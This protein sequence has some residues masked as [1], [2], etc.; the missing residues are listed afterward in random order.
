[1][2]GPVKCTPKTC[3]FDFAKNLFPAWFRPEE[4]TRQAAV[5]SYM[6]AHQLTLKNVY[7]RAGCARHFCTYRF[8]IYD[9]PDAIPGPVSS[10]RW[11]APSATD[12]GCRLPQGFVF[13]PGRA[14]PIIQAAF[15]RTPD[16]ATPIGRDPVPAPRF[17]GGCG[18]AEDPYRIS[19]AKELLLLS[20]LSN[21]RTCAGV[22]PSLVEEI[23]G[24]FPAWSRNKHFR[25]TRDIVW[26]DPDGDPADRVSFPII[27]NRNGGWGRSAHFAGT[28][29]GAG[30]FISGLFVSEE[31]EKKRYPDVEYAYNNGVSLFGSLQGTVKNLAIT[32]SVFIGSARVAAF[33]GVMCFGGAIENCLADNRILLFGTSGDRNAGGLVGFSVN[34]TISRSVVGGEILGSVYSNV[35]F[36]GGIF[37]AV[38]T[39][40]TMATSVSDCFVFAS[41]REQ[42]DPNVRRDYPAFLAL[43]GEKQVEI[44]RIREGV[45]NLRI[46]KGR[47]VG[48][49]GSVYVVN[50]YDFFQTFVSPSDAERTAVDFVSFVLPQFSDPA[51]ASPLYP[52]FS[53][54]PGRPYFVNEIKPD[55]P[56]M[57]GIA[58]ALDYLF[59]SVSGDVP[60][61]PSAVPP[62][63]AEELH[64]RAGLLRFVSEAADH[65]LMSLS[66]ERKERKSA[67]FRAEL[68]DWIE[69]NYRN[70]LTTEEAARRFF[71]SK[72]Y[73]CRQFRQ[74][75]GLPFAIYLQNFRIRKSKQLDPAKFP[76]LAS[77]AASV[78]FPS[79]YHFERVF[80]QW[81]GTT[82]RAYFDAV[83]RS[84]A[85]PFADEDDLI[86]K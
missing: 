14:I 55:H 63:T 15:D 65:G 49:P 37:G 36:L 9:D 6:H 79:Y 84:A 18:T 12:P 83:R 23:A 8:T 13:R 11:I 51:E 58:A 57:P 19:S 2:N 21:H 30:H 25:L 86:Q 56:G 77:L 81:M 45:L 71:L 80:R 43:H 39:G 33:A 31:E 69:K 10:C 53:G 24:D 61:H 85:T 73:F 17:A 66:V 35:S 78:G 22:D 26:N 40:A 27:A 29:D 60:R 72:S 32:R 47:Y 44:F 34:G 67:K 3:V 4:S 62:E 82:P 68:I 46:G 74:E 41:I 70:K 20:S 54:Q 1:M 76:S 64:V 52:L 28:F 38:A 16:P 7:A 59:G 5:V 48:L 75:F 50:P 42:L